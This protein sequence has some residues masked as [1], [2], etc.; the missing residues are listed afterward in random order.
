MSI[1]SD[2]SFYANQET[3]NDY[4]TLANVL[5]EVL[6]NYEQM[7]RSFDNMCCI[8]ATSPMLRSEDLSNGFHSLMESDFSTIIP[9]VQFSYPILRSFRMNENGGLAYN[10]PE[11]AKSRSQ[12]LPMH[13]MTLE[14]FIGTK[15][16]SGVRGRFLVEVLYSVR[17]PFRTL[18]RNKI[19][20]W[21]RLSI[22]SNIIFF[23]YM[24]KI[25]FW[26]D[27]D[28][29]IGYGHF[30]R[31]L[32]LAEML[33]DDFDCTFFTQFPTTFQKVEVERICKLVAL[34]NNETKFDVFLNLLE[35][36][37]IVFL[38]NY[39][40]SSSYQNKSK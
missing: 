36:K 14:H 35:E 31:T 25:Y 34:P 2:S 18:I 20:K 24:S 17:I 26:A 15:S 11:Y 4:A 13:I 9:I 6:D 37:V 1:W 23:S 19:G 5:H 28:S 38:D 32:A 10:W 30:I 21:R 8:L 3:A 40:F 33:K 39:F 7:G 12:D 16:I 27:A 22:K 29:Y